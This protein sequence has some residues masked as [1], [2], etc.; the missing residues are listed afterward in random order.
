[1]QDPNYNLLSRFQHIMLISKPRKVKDIVAAASS[2]RLCL[3]APTIDVVMRACNGK[4]PT[5]AHLAC[6]R[7]R[8]RDKGLVCSIPEAVL[9]GEPCSPIARSSYCA[10]QA[11]LLTSAMSK[12]SQSRHL[13]RPPLIIVRMD[14]L[15][16]QEKIR[17]TTQHGHH[18]AMYHLVKSCIPQNP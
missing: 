9:G 12:H 7:R 13:G 18:I 11:Q 6:P 2:T 1:M 4:R 15:H 10:V 16:C 17:R 3:P 5:D 14:S 8:V